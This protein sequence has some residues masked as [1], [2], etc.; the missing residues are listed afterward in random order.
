MK[1]RIKAFLAVV[2]V[3][4]VV[5]SAM[6]TRVQIDLDGGIGIYGP[7]PTNLAGVVIRGDLWL[8]NFNTTSPTAGLLWATGNII[9]S[10]NIHAIGDIYGRT[11]FFVHPHPTNDTKVIRYITVESGEAL[12]VVRG[13][14]KTVNGEATIKLPEHFSLVTSAME[15][16]TV[17]LT[18]IGAPALL[19]T[20]QASKDEIVVAIGNDFRDVEFAY[21]VT[22]I[23]DGFENQTV[24]MDEEKLDTETTIREDVLERINA[25]N[26]RVRARQEEMRSKRM[27]E[28]EYFEQP[29][30]F[31][32]I[33]IPN[34]NRETETTPTFNQPAQQNYINNETAVATPTATETLTG[35]FVAGPNPADRR[36]GA[37]MNFFYRGEP[38]RN[39]QLKIYD[40]AGKVVNKIKINDRMPGDQP[41]SWVALWDL[42]DRRG[43]L[44]SEGTYLVRGTLVTQDGKRERVMITVGV[45]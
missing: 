13:T 27:G 7:A 1:T 20:R 38:I 22:G 25:Y 3:G 30:E 43:R 26:E 34:T 12:T 18:P 44:V 23:R 35:E 8:S 36:A 32:E 14:A 5:F 39:G 24:I 19:Y 9:T 40:D 29:A 28:S 11:K 37:V 45:R 17:I 21:Q 15:P 6:A 16:V 10:S 42:T 41:N 31:N 4:G 2:L 33:N